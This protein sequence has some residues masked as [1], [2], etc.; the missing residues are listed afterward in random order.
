MS[1]APIDPLG[2]RV[3]LP[4]HFAEPVIVEEV[5]DFGDLLNL[6]VRTARGE[7][8]ETTIEAGE[9]A[10]A[11]AASA[12]PSAPAYVD[13]R[14]QFLLIESARIRHAYA[15]D[16]FFAVSLSGIEPLPHQLEAVYDRMLRQ[17]RLR[18]LLAD[19]P[20]AGKTIMAGLLI[21]ELRLRGAVDRVLILSP[22][23]LT[24]QWQDEMKAKFD[25][26]FEIVD[27]HAARQQLSGSPWKKFP[28][29]IAS[30]DFAKQ[31]H[32][33]PDLLQERWDLVII[34]EAH[35]VAMPDPEQPTIRYQLAR[36]LAE[37]T[38]RLLLLTATPHQGNSAQFRN[39]MALLD[40][41]AFR[42]DEVVRKLLQTPDSPWMM[43][44]MKETL[45][46]FQG[47]KLFVE[48]H[49]WTETFALNA[50][51][52]ALYSEVSRYI[53][54]Y[55]PRQ[56]GRR[57]QSAA[58]ARMVLQRRLASS[59]RAIRVSLERRQAKLRALVD[60]LA[61]LPDD[62][63]LLRLR[64]LANLRV[65]PEADPDDET[66]DQLDALAEG[67]FL[68]ERWDQL[69]AEVEALDQ[70]VP[71]AHRAEG[72]NQETKLDALF[73]CLQRSE[74]QE[75][76]ERSGKLLIFTEHRTTLDYLVEKLTREGYSC[77]TI[78]GGMDAVTR[79]E[80]QR[81]FQQSAQICVATE[82]AGEG[83][84]L[85]FC[86]LMINYDIPWN[87]NRLEQRMGRIHRIGQQR[88]VHV[89]N[90]VAV[91]GPEGRDRQPVIEGQILD[92][93]LRKLDEIRKTLGDRVFD[94]IGML[95]R[96]NGFS[97]EDVLREATLNPKKLDDYIHD[98]ERLSPEALKKYEE[99]T[100]IALAKNLVDLGRVRGERW[101]SEERR[102]MPEFVEDWFLAAAD[103]TGLRIG[104]RANPRLLRIDAVPQKFRAPS[105]LAVRT[106]GEPD[107]RYP[108]ATFHKDELKK[109]DN[110]DGALLS[111][112]HPLYAAVDELLGLDLRE[113]AG[114]TARYL[115]AAACEPY[116]LHFFEVEV[117]GESLGD[118]GE[119]PRTVPVHAT[120]IAALE[121]ADGGFSL[122][123]PDVLHD[124]KAV[125]PGV[126]F[127]PTDPFEGPPGPEELTRVQ[128]WVKARVQYPLVKERKDE[129]AREVAI[130]RDFLSQAYEA[131]LKEARR[132][133]MELASRVTP[134]DQDSRLARD[135]AFAR[136]KELEFER[137]HRLKSLLHLEVVRTGRVAWLGS[138][139]VAPSPSPLAVEMRRDDAVELLAIDLA[140]RHEEARGWKVEDIW[141]R[142]DGSGFDLR[143]T[144]PEDASG[145][146]PV[147][148]IE[149]KGRA[150]AAG[151][152]ALTPNEWRKAQ[153]FRDSYWLYVVWGCKSG[154]PRLKAIPDP[155]GVLHGAAREVVELTRVQIDAEALMEAPGEEWSG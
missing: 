128:G 121:A 104:K 113:S 38:E 150:A 106:R 90:F 85:Q 98:I 118:P 59:L 2:R 147:R 129:R 125:A 26:L 30:I 41:H 109:V 116:R 138:A 126:L 84:N 44:R 42:N 63:R 91:S 119:P 56:Q 149:V 18:F 76:R 108:K 75:L 120:V 46:D 51:E 68:A 82:A 95:L 7:L 135:R 148:R 28:R 114:G 45:R 10:R 111:P 65:D 88:E 39:F 100:G 143:S 83:I 71:L 78:H 27:S 99:A 97:L 23:P 89:F 57:K 115:D 132:K 81:E 145:V 55:L 60:E 153:R 80:K 50:E 105:L 152:I 62:K 8:K 102:L 31:D 19:D 20:G 92:R 67:A 22:A 35:K 155:W 77:C 154:A 144:G 53:N 93:L 96:Q 66:D 142:R 74:F 12:A 127:P 133:A 1:A 9:L 25:E 17:A 130:R 140:R 87:P 61:L 6:R 151:A 131:S 136:V 124:L 40:D 79:K 141:K 48:R 73:H 47:R 107:G 4:G 70:L 72:R 21:K 86:H 5:Q 117:E 43:R 34:D 32:V 16:P 94:V 69:Q 54:T 146:R 14:D 13:P 110:L 134:E 139:L 3:S 52:F 103:R 64:E 36:P 33:R 123:Q 137:E 37:R 29:C 122:G 112:G 49:A 101:D 58:L 11:L 24:L 15:W